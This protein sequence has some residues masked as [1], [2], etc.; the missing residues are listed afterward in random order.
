MAP[1]EARVAAFVLKMAFQD[2]SFLNTTKQAAEEPS[3]VSTLYP[4]ESSAEVST[5]P[6]R[7]D[8]MIPLE[9]NLNADID[10]N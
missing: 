6:V 3:I 5:L 4:T 7:E 1:T 8:Q 10:A 2:S 9:E